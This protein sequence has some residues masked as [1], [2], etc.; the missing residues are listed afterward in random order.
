MAKKK[1]VTVGSVLNPRE[2][3]TST[4]PY[5]RLNGYTA[6]D[7][8][9]ALSKVEKNKGVSLSLQTRDEQIAN[10][11]KAAANGKLSEDLATKMISNLEKYK[12]SVKYDLVLVTE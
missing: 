4:R 7:L 9:A 6:Q 8:I 3:S 1:Y 10:I 12:E 5:V 11:Q 2:G